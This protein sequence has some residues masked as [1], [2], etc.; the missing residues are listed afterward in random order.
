MVFDHPR[1]SRLSLKSRS[2]VLANC[3]TTKAP[4]PAGWPDV[5]PIKN[6]MNVSIS[7]IKV[8]N[9]SRRYSLQS[10]NKDAAMQQTST[11]HGNTAETMRKIVTDP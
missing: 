8:I 9:G 2:D 7:A 3:N 5:L 6:W 1:K 4:C 10:V 11:A